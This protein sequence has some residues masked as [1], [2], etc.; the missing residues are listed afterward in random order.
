M[1]RVRLHVTD[2]ANFIEKVRMTKRASVRN[3]S[4]MINDGGETNEIF[5]GSKSANTK[6]NFVVCGALV[7]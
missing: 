1:K 5:Q 7:N 6:N 2:K 4:L 3:V